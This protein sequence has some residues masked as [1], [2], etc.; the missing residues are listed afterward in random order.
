MAGEKHFGNTLFGFNKHDVNSYIENLLKDF[1]NKVKEHEVEIARLSNENKEL[2]CKYE[3]IL[4]KEEKT[5]QEKERIAEVL[6]KAQEKAQLMIEDAKTKAIEERNKIQEITEQE[7]EKLVD[8]KEEI[9]ILKKSITGTL[10]KY[11]VQLGGII[12]ESIESDYS[13]EGGAYN[14]AAVTIYPN[15]NLNGK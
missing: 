14:E 10:K 4:T 15:E 8:I 11:E 5:N 2:R 6:I 13:K 9:R 1:E 7:K 12:D 3:Q